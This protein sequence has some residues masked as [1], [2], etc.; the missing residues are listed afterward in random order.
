[1]K[2]R[3]IARRIYKGGDATKGGTQAA[4]IIA[5]VGIAVGLVVMIVTIAV[6]QGFK[7]QIREKV[8]GFTSHIRITNS[9]TSFGVNEMP[10]TTSQ[11][12]FSE[13]EC[14]RHVEYVQRYIDKPGIIRTDSDF[15]G[16]LLRGVGQ[17]YDLSF[18]KSYLIEGEIPL[19]S[20]TLTSND[21]LLS[22][23]LAD[24]MCLKVGDKVDIYF[25][26]NSV[27]ARRMTLRGIYQTNFYE[28]D[29]T[30]GITDIYTLQRLN[31]WNRNQAYGV[32]IYLKNSK[33]LDSAYS[34]IRHIMKRHSDVM[35]ESYLTRTMEQINAGIF[36]WLDVLNV[37][38]WVIL[39]LMMGIA[40][41]TI[42]S[43]LLIIIFERTSMI[44]V[45]KALGSN[46]TSIRKIFL[47]LSTYIIVRG[48]IIG[49]IF[50]IGLCLVQSYFGVFK[51]NP[52][53]YYLDSVPVE[54]NLTILIILNVVMFILSLL[55][56]LGPSAVIGRIYPSQSIR[57]E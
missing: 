19:F 1:M 7:H 18:I 38:V 55:M 8:I 46:N 11:E 5:T 54:L 13:L 24:K 39:L 41:F 42:I 29:N 48:M 26:Q 3:F 50:G 33:E 16:F 52:Q 12:I 25:I 43:G 47:N 22:K 44:G 28:Y 20:D 35:G 23:V 17:E 21:L 15:K 30:Y 56:L 6:T 14:C 32:E 49:N 31:G 4:V 2:E 37:N 53:N 36:A 10:I 57:F 34:E 40:G 45:L 51:L 9:K 27:R